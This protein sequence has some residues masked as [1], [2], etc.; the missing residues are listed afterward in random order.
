METTR[1]SLPPQRPLSCPDLSR[2]PFL[3]GVQ[4][5]LHQLLHGIAFC[6][7]HRVL[8]RDLK[9]Q[10]RAPSYLRLWLWACGRAIGLLQNL[11]IN[12]DGCLKLAD[13]GLARA[14]GIPVRTYTHEVV[15]LWCVTPL[16]APAVDRRLVGG[17]GS[18]MPTLAGIVRPRSCSARA[19]T[20]HPLTSGRLGAYSQR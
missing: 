17:G 2:G 11:L 6:H 3:S 12:H 1:R 13:F 9:P 8:H 20:P 16:Q 4:S 14:F 5:Y 15:T 10:V 18:I 7:S 19:T